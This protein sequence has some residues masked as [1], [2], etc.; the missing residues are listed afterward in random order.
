M[1]HRKH[2]KYGHRSTC[3]RDPV[4]HINLPFLVYRKGAKTFLKLQ[5]FHSFSWHFLMIITSVFYPKHFIFLS[6]MMIKWT[7][8]HHTHTQPFVYLLIKFNNIKFI[9]CRRPKH[10]LF[11]FVITYFKCWIFL[12]F[13]NSHFVPSFF[14][15]FAFTMCTFRFMS[16]VHVASC[17]MDEKEKF[18]QNHIK[19]TQPKVWC[20]VNIDT[21]IYGH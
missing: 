5:N 16:I 1:C 7:W 12:F 20:A 21:F 19:M 18:K 4:L 10:G 9:F 6:Y 11:H 14:I 13:G 3:H 2:S 8:S 15:A 17:R